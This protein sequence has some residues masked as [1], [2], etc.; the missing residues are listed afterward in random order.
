MKTKQTKKSRLL[1]NCGSGNEPGG[2]DSIRKFKRNNP[3]RT[4][5]KST[6]KFSYKL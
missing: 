4:S 6:Y 1:R 5:F 2:H 3:I